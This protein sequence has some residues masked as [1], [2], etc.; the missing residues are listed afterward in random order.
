M[1]AVA[2]DD[3]VAD[4]HVRDIVTDIDPCVSA[5]MLTDRVSGDGNVAGPRTLTANKDRRKATGSDVGD[6]VPVHGH[7]LS[8]AANYESTDAGIGRCPRIGVHQR[9]PTDRSVAA[10]R[11]LYAIG[12][13]AFKVVAGDCHPSAVRQRYAHRATPDNVPID[14]EALHITSVDSVWLVWKPVFARVDRIGFQYIIVD[15]SVA[16]PA[17]AFDADESDTPA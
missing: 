3:V 9:V 16:R 1:H 10:C 6:A 8:G 2:V 11:Y 12:F 14:D 5:G 7:V 4:S 15:D 17:A 13:P